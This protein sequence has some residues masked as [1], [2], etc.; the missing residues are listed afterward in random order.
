MGV[1]GAVIYVLA[2]GEEGGSLAAYGF[3][4]PG[5]VARIDELLGDLTPGAGIEGTLGQMTLDGGEVLVTI[6][7]SRTELWGA[8]LS[9]SGGFD[10]DFV[11]ASAE[12]LP[13]DLIQMKA[14]ELYG[15]SYA[16]GTR[17]G[18]DA[19][20]IW[21]VASDGSFQ[22]RFSVSSGLGS[23][24]MGI[25]A[26]ETLEVGGKP[27]LLA[28]S[29]GALTLASYTLNGAGIPTMLANV[30]MAGGMGIATPTDLAV[31]HVNGQSFALV[32][33]AGS[34]SLTVFRVSATGAL[35]AIDH[36]LDDRATRFANVTE[37]EV[38]QV[39][40]HAFAALAGSDD[41]ISLFQIL[42]TGRIL[43]LQSL[44][45]H[46]ETVLRNVSALALGAEGGHLQIY[47]SGA[48]DGLTVF[49]T[50]TALAGQLHQ[51]H[52][53]GASLVG[54][55]GYDVLQGGAGDDYLIAGSGGGVLIDG[56][57]RD[58]LQGGAGQD[59][60]ILDFDGDYD[61]VTDFDPTQDRLDLSA[62]Q[63]LRS[64]AQLDVET[65][66]GGANIRFNGER[67]DIRTTDANPLSLDDLLS[68][69]LIAQSRILPEWVGYA[70]DSEIEGA[71]SRLTG[72]AEADELHGGAGDEELFGLGSEDLLRGNAGDDMLNGGAGADF[73]NGGPGSDTYYVDDLGDRISESRKWAGTDHV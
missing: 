62:W 13:S 8:A 42:P 39:G 65:V 7:A 47:A 41:G 27:L 12:P 73:M 29:D 25:A 33:A 44:E 43:H 61:I 16:Y 18:S 52:P 35:T 49:E 60:F 68:A 9:P 17:L 50:E 10:G 38:I 15:T 66:S 30:A 67:L 26:F 5:S 21:R 72:T 23:S 37:L 71:L 51:A 34:S 40:P 36:V 70:P 46:T 3:S 31:A 32:A 59:V 4:Q 24:T 55:A 56:A 63:F 64:S 58:R 28:A 53:G 45:D 6:G 69:G 1:P 48:E 57:G 54:G 2:R 14:A 22:D 20:D 19:F 11:I